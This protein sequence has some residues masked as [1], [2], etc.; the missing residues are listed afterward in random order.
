MGKLLGLFFLISP[1]MALSQM[2]TVELV[3]KPVPKPITRDTATDNWNQS[4]PEYQNLSNGAK[5]VLYWTN[6]CRSRP[7]KF[8]DSVVIPILKAFP[9][10]EGS[11]S[12]E[13]KQALQQTG[14]LPMFKL[15][16][17]LLKTSQEHANDICRKPSTPS[18]SSTN[19]T[20]FGSRMK[21]V[22][23][24]NCASENMSLGNQ[25]PLLSVILLYLDIG[26]PDLGHRKSLLNPQL[27]ELGIGYA[28]YDKGRFFIVEDLACK[29]D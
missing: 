24:Y 4:Q 22:G 13:L 10:L 3:I 21:L 29:Q 23:I 14:A 12:Q 11:E 8:W 17:V 28:K 27:V 1:L 18:H 19:G 5:D 16:R 2:S 25:D 9:T 6:F 26:L 20:S 7:M 15:N